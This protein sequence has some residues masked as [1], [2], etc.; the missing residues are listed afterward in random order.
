[1]SGVRAVFRVASDVGLGEQSTV[2]VTRLR[3]SDGELV[4]LL[5][6]VYRVDQRNHTI[7]Q[8]ALAQNVMGEKDLNNRAGVS[9]AAIQSPVGRMQYRRNRGCRAGLIVHLPARWIGCSRC[10]RWSGL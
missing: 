10:S 6:S 8:V 7:Q 9:H 3:L 1:M 5:I 2:G 4:H